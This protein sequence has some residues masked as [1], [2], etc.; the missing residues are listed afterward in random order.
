[1]TSQH[2]KFHYI[3]LCYI[4]LNYITL[5]YTTLHELHYFALHFIT[6]HDMTWHYITTYTHTCMHALCTHRH[7]YQQK[8]D[9]HLYMYVCIYVCTRYIL[10]LFP[11][12]LPAQ[13]L[14]KRGSPLEEAEAEARRGPG[15]SLARESCRCPESTTTSL[16]LV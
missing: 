2:I 9:T 3:T 6:L 16:G 4:T 10:F 13:K 15:T 14:Y 7:A 11:H 8:K 5:H 12:V 1:M